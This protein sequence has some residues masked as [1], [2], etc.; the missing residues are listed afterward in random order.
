LS[1][2]NFRDAENAKNNSNHQHILSNPIRVTWKKNTKELSA[3]SNI[4]VKNLDENVTV[5]DLDSA[6]SQYG[7]IFSS[8]IAYDESGKSRRYG[9]VQFDSK[10]GAEKCLQDAENI[11]IK[12]KVVEITSFLKK[13]NRVDPR[14]NLYIKNMPEN[15][16]E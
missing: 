7:A 11:K 8:K 9:Y 3:E 1:F 2:Y 13:E 6:F 16:I 5:A 4:F 14:K 15:T 10:D 12:G